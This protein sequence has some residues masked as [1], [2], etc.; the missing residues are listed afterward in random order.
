MNQFVVAK[1]LRLSSADDNLKQGG[2]FES[3]SIQNQR[4][5]LDTF[6]QNAPELAEAEVVEFCD[7]GWSGTNFERPAVQKLLTQVRNGKIQ[8]IIVKDIS[9]FGRDYLTVGRYLFQIFPSLGVRFIALN[10]GFDSIRSMEVDSLGTSFKTL[11]YD[12]YSWDLSSKV[13][14]TLHFR[15]K[16]GK[17]LSPFAP[18][19]YIK[20]PDNKNLLMIDPEAAE[21]VRR[22][23]QMA[24]AGQ[25]PQ[26][27][28]KALNQEDVPT[29]MMYKQMMGCT[30]TWS[31]I[32]GENFWTHVLVAKILRDERYTGKMV[33]GKRTRD[34]VGHI[35]TTKVKRAE[36]TTV[37][38]TH[39]GIVT[40]EQFDRA[41][42][43][44]R[45]FMERNEISLGKGVPLY[46]KVRCGVCGHTMT[47]SKTKQPYYFCKTS[48]VTDIFL[49]TEEHLPEC[50]L[51][52]AIRKSLH[53]QA[54]LA[55]EWKDL[56]QEQQKREQLSVATME[57]H[58]RTLK[59]ANDKVGQQ[60]RELYESFALGKCSKADY[61][62]AK[63]VIAGQRDTIATQIV[64][65]EAQLK[66]TDAD[67]GLNNRFISSL[68]KYEGVENIT[69]E[70]VSDVVKEVLVYPGGRFEIIWTYQEDFERLLMAL[71]SGGYK[72]PISESRTS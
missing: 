61:L 53:M 8:C 18:Y 41:Q 68:Q 56:W 12:L 4:N 59:K 51:M 31:S 50:D 2:K 9:R 22:I 60:S 63:R 1:Y 15:A 54:L 24:V 21:I 28:A 52:E 72:E 70:I 32:H 67:G 13:R 3:D 42:A 5:L 64:E 43:S 47:H 14:S 29:P 17:F 36:W 44:L 11:L 16:E 23:F 40:Q 33:Y 55:V 38:N 20:H 10:D 57:K 37:E 26:H 71:N 65:L 34:K 48:R 39:A 35:H 30:R 46:K 45:K 69:Q 7:D 66:N 27:I 62:A 49:C 58:L 19:G 6:I 25:R